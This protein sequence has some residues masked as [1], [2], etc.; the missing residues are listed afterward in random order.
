MELIGANILANASREQM[1]YTIDCLG[2]HTPAALELLADSV[3]NPE[4]DAHEIE[5]Q[6]ARLAAVLASPEVQL[7]LLTELLVRGAYDGGLA[8]PLIPDPAA[9]SHLTPRVLGAF[10]RDQFLGPRVVLA[11]AGVDHRQLVDLAAPM[12]SQLPA[13]GGGGGDSERASSSGG[14]S[15]SGSGSGSG[16]PAS[17]YVGCHTLVPGSAPQT[18]IILAFEYG[19]GW[20]DI[21]VGRGE[22]QDVIWGGSACDLS[23]RQLLIEQEWGQQAA[24]EQL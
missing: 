17:R 14:A 24:A 5:E 18:N 15:S 20:H 16:E 12:L 4:F 3:L 22:R 11:G 8:R 1:S 10:V 19:G 6:K 2:S 21:Q 23:A 9:L 13:G 7:T